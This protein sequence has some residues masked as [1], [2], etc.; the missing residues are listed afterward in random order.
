MVL[1]CSIGVQCIRWCWGAVLE[2]SVLG[3]VGVQYLGAVSEM[4]LVCSIGLQCIRWCWGAVLEYSV[5]DGVGVQY[6]GAVY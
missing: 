5:L 6:L 4:V 1:G 2:C 3:G